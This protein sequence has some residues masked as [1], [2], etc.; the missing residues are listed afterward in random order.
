MKKIPKI[1]I[2][3]KRTKKQKQISDSYETGERL[4]GKYQ[5]IPDFDVEQ[6]IKWFKS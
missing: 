1:K 3:K 2:K 6:T 5:I 4:I